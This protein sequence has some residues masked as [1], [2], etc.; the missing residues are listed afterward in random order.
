[1][2]ILPFAINVFCY[3][4]RLPWLSVKSFLFILPIICN[5]NEWSLVFDVQLY[6]H[7]EKI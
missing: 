3:F 6:Y 2:F 7:V 4:V 5:F 1:M